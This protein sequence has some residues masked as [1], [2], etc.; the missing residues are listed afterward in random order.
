MSEVASDATSQMVEDHEEVSLGALRLLGTFDSFEWSKSE[1]KPRTQTMSEV[2]SDA[3]S[4]MVPPAGFEPTTFWTGTKR[5][6]QLSYEGKN[7][8][9]NLFIQQSIKQ[10]QGRS[11]HQNKGEPDQTTR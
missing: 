6:I 4:Q 2:A 8:T 9:K 10:A 3:T 1:A 11:G 5:S 7:L